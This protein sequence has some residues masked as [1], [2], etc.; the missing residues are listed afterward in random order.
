MTRRLPPP[1]VAL[2]PGVLAEAGEAAFLR[3][4]EAAVRAGLSG[5]LVREPSMPDRPLLALASACRR[6]LPDGA[7]LA[8]H[9][10]VHLA[11]ACGADAVHLG[12]RSLAPEIA[13]GLVEDRIAVGLSAHAA[14]DPARW[15]AADYLFFGPVFDTPSKRG[16][17]EPTGIDGLARALERSRVPVWAIGGIAAGSVESCIAAGCRGV[18]VLSGVLGAEDPGAACRAYLARMPA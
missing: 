14:D 5:L 9:D 13:R 2:S 6:I 4:L 16:V 18:A 11:E 3:A 1:L 15:S 7:W 17:L 12:F 10:R 8:I